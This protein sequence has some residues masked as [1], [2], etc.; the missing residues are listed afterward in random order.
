VKP[1]VIQ[2]WKKMTKENKKREAKKGVI[3]VL[4]LAFVF[5]IIGLGNISATTISPT[6]CWCGDHTCNGAETCST[7]S[8]DCGTCPIESCNIELTK[9]VSKTNVKPNDT[10]TYTLHYKNTGNT[11]CTG[12]GVRIEDM[13]DSNLLYLGSFT[14]NVI[15]D[16]DSDGI[17]AAWYEVPGFDQLT[18]TLTWNVH[19]VS[20]GEEGT[21][22]F[23]VKVLTPAHC[24]SFQIPNYFRAWSNQ[25]NWKSS[26][27]RNV[28]VNYDCP[29]CG[30]NLVNQ[31]NETCDDGNTNNNDGCSSTCKTERCGD[32]I[33]QANEQ[34]DDG[35]TN[36]TD[37]CR[38]NCQL[39]KCGDGEINLANETCDDGN[40]ANGDGCSSECKTE[41]L[42]YCGDGTVNKL[43]EECDKGSLNGQTCTPSYGGTCTYCSALCKNITLTDGYCGD[44]QIQN[45]PEECD[46][47]NNNNGDG[48]SSDCKTEFQQCQYNVS[49]RYSYVNSFGTG[50]AINNSNTYNWVS[51]NPAHLSQGL[52]KIRYYVDNNINNKT[53]NA[54]ITVKLDNTVLTSY[55]QVIG[56]D[57]YKTLSLDTSNLLCDST[58]YITVEVKSESNGICA[59]DSTSDNFANRTIYIDCGEQHVC[60][61]GS[62]DSGEE[63]DLGTNNGHMC[64]PAYGGVCTYCSNKCEEIRLTDGYCGDGLI[65]NP[66]EQC[67]DG[68]LD[69]EDGCSSTCQNETQKQCIE[70][71]SIRKSYSNS[72]GTGIALGYDNGTWISAVSPDLFKGVY[73]ARYYV[74]NNVA[75]TTNNATIV[76][77]LD[78][79]VLADYFYLIS[80]Y[81]SKT[82]TID[83]TGL[84]CNSMHKISVKAESQCTSICIQDDKSDNYAERSFFVMCEAPRCGDG[85]LDNGEECDDGNT[86]ND[87]GCSSTCQEEC[88][89]YCGDGTKQS[90]EQCDLG[91]A[92][93]GHVCTPLYNSSCVYCS[94]QC[95]NITLTDGKC[96]DA[97]VQSQY[98][99]CDLGSLNNHPC[100]P[101]YGGSCTY[102][103]SSCK[104]V[105]LTD[106]YCGD[107][108]VQSQYEQC[109]LG[110]LNNHPCTPL[111]GGSCTYCNSSCKNVTLTDGSCGD[112]VVQSQYEQCDLGS[113]NNHPCTPLYGG[114]CTYCS[115]TCTNITLTDGYCGDSILQ[116]PPEQCDLGALNNHPCTP[117]YGGSCTYCNSSCKNVTLT[118]GYCGDSVIQSQYEQCDLGTAL[119]NHPCTPL[120]GGSC[121]YCNSSCKN[122]TLTDGYCGDSVIQSQ[123]E[124]CDLGSLNNHPCTPLYGGSCTYCSATCTNITLTDGYCGDSVI[125]SQ[126]EQCDLGTALNGQVCSPLYGSSCSYC[127]ATCK[128]ITLTNGSCGDNIVQS[129]YEQCDDGNHINGDLCSSTCR[130]EFCGD[131]LVNLPN[132]TCDDGN[133]ANNDGCSS[134]CKTERC[135]D[136]IKQA[137]ESCDDGNTNNTD[138][139][140]NNCKLPYCGDGIKDKT[141][142]CDDGNQA[143]GDGCS[144]TCRYECPNGVCTPNITIEKFPPI[145]WQCDNRVIMDDATKPGRIT[146]DGQP[147]LERI[148]DYAFEGEQIQWKVLVMDKNGIE[149]VKDV[150]TTVDGNIEANCRLDH[151]VNSRETIEADCNARIGEENITHVSDNVAAYYICT[152]TVE[153][154][155]SM[156]GQSDVTVEAIDL[157]GEIGTMAEE[158]SWFFNPIISLGVDGSLTFS[159][160]RPGTS[161]Y[162][163]PI[164]VTNDAEEG[165]GVILDMFVSGTDF[166]DSSSSGAKCGTSNQLSLK[167]FSYFATNGEYSTYQDLEHGRTCDAEGYCSVNYGIGFNDP[168]RFY[169]KN[170][171]LQAQQVGP[172]YAGNL[173]APGADMSLTFRV[174]VPEPCNGNFNSGH[175]Y[176][177]GEAV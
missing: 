90:N 101:L 69:N 121:T 21:I 76:V 34:C 13:L 63:C 165:S 18:N 62:V 82:I 172:Y 72:F 153:T 154:P 46:D 5:L 143:S 45:P 6:T 10:I 148:N 17:D 58:H 168:Y 77:K 25:E 107:W 19:R 52:H 161:E 109:D 3:L 1:E 126:Y 87:D 102:C 130:I 164:T 40:I 47:R 2:R 118:D 7:C 137:N 91:T 89:P 123:Y 156:H 11:V 162:S 116:N 100:T 158:E 38:N 177:W 106:G 150:Y 35:N 127:N 27:T 20:P 66:P 110:S 171:I 136:A 65:Q 157:D 23:D 97:V 4:A 104:N 122:V 73:K 32:A 9:S 163:G 16:G 159:S 117:L 141:E 84:Q 41:C 67:D 113:L 75:N 88:L 80:K 134:T 43:G 54:S 132:E 142:Y 99:Q 140:R 37:G 151:M 71:I 131:H 12:G 29:V 115:A 108:V 95:Q 146:T 112:S 59:N 170:E 124:Q 114:S 120:Y 152:L 86:N 8:T 147:I 39:P 149:K 51:E 36:N 133:Y 55:Y 81:H 74:D 61:D 144:K 128:N 139:C 155:E 26:N 42:P 33:K 78:N 92:L 30:D 135:G 57:H 15:N 93:N 98:E 138:G 103:N 174:D 175:I 167:Q 48:C 31:A 44:G 83:T 28:N 129:Q 105:T 79:T 125:Q 96:G 94:S 14:K 173:L 64:T 49:V 22:T 53:N 145:I 70:N 160:L 169:D 119:N 111:Y 176:F 60:G 50:I 85:N 166:Y 68:N 56:Q 24:G